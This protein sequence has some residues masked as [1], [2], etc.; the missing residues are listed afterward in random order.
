MEVVLKN[1]YSI[2]VSRRKKQQCRQT[3]AQFY[4]GQP[5]AIAA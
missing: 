3:I 4:S 1:Y 5:T 2:P